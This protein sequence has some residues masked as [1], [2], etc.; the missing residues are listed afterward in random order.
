LD[1]IVH[2]E[3][4]RNY[5]IS[6][7]DKGTPTPFQYKKSLKG[8]SCGVV[9]IRMDDAGKLSLEAIGR[10]VEASRQVR[11]TVYRRRLFADPSLPSG[12]S[13]D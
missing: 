5:L 9:N 10:F 11:G 2:V 8:R 3:I 1:E 7:T 13:F 4:H 12:S 6:G